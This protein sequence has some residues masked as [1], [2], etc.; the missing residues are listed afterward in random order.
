MALNIF[1][2]TIDLSQPQQHIISVLSEAANSP[3]TDIEHF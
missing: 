3:N 2:C 1:V